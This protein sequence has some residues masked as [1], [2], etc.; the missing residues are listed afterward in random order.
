MYVFRLHA[1]DFSSTSIFVPTIIFVCTVRA[2]IWYDIEN[3]DR[4]KPVILI[5]ALPSS[6]TRHRNT[7]F[8]RT[9]NFSIIYPLM[10]WIYRCGT[11]QRLSIIT[12][13]NSLTII[14]CIRDKRTDRNQV[15]VYSHQKKFPVFRS[16][17]WIGDT[18]PQLI[19]AEISSIKSVFF[20]KSRN[21]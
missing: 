18:E 5:S 1:F 4:V 8:S 11:K 21:W 17:T 3:T 7:F 13:A 6:R 15:V 20:R 2:L 9:Y 10:I 19:V 16:L 14:I 12:F